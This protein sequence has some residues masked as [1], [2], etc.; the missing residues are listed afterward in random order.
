MTLLQQR[1]MLD[2]R[3]GGEITFLAR[4][5]LIGGV[6]RR[7]PLERVQNHRLVTRL[8][9]HPAVCGLVEGLA[10]LQLGGFGEAAA[11]D[12]L[13]DL[14]LGTTDNAMWTDDHESLAFFR[15]LRNGVPN[16][17]DQPT[18]AKVYVFMCTSAARMARIGKGSLTRDNLRGRR[19]YHAC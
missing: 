10:R 8:R 4:D 16:V 15:G 13:R 2:G 14:V 1:N 19:K 5:F 18:R 7:R 17:V 11:V 9:V 6:R 3:H 12:T